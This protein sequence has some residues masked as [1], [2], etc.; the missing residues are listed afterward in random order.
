[1]DK[2]QTI[3]FGLG[4]ASYENNDSSKSNP[5]RISRLRQ[6]WADGWEHEDSMSLGR[7]MA[8]E[9]RR[10]HIQDVLQ[11]WRDGREAL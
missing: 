1:M 6:A 5:F 10:E 8:E 7:K 11:E 3:A 2:L 4:R 9:Q